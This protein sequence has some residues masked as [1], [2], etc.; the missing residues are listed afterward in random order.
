LPPI[1]AVVYAS[2]GD[3]HY[4]WYQIEEARRYFLRALH[5]SILGGS[6]T[7]T[8]FCRVLLSRLSQIEGDLEIAAREIQDAADLVPVEAPEYVRKEVIAQQVSIYL[9]RNQPAA[10][11]IALQGQGFSFGDRFSFP[12]FPPGESISYS[13]GL[14]YNSGLRVLLYQARAGKDA[15][16]LRPGLKLANRLIDRAF[17]GQQ[18]LIMLETL[19]LRAQLHDVLGD[20]PASTADYVKA[21]ALAEPEGFISV[22]VEQ[23]Q[24]V[25]KEL[26]E[27]IKRKQLGKNIR[28]DYVER[29]LAVF[30]GSHL[31][32][33]EQPASVPST[34][35]EPMSLIEPL[36]E[37]ELEVL[38]LMVMGLKYKE[39]AARLFISQNTVRFHIKAIYGKLNVNN[40]TQ[41]IERARQLRIL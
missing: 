29:I 26:A 4:Q 10:A 27:L 7:I 25:A 41:A 22:F 31:T 20:H 28:T 1:S 6:N 5:L 33:D 12:D 18:V 2:L 9:A 21:L 13:V 39:I 17:Q 16:R 24:P 35:I 11:E 34:K 8:I 15:T 19:L 14:L 36:T 30:S 23:G 37:R 40:R 38:S 32:R 3:A